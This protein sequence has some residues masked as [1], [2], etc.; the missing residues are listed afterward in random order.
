MNLFQRKTNQIQNAASWVQ[1]LV[2]FSLNYFGRT[3]KSAWRMWAVVRVWCS[4]KLRKNKHTHEMYVKEFSKEDN[5][6]ICYKTTAS[7]MQQH[8]P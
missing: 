7:E 2:I 3:T 5:F 4:A 8:F 1:I 6:R